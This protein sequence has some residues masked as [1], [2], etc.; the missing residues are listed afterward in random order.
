MRANL[1]GRIDYA[2]VRIF[3]VV[4]VPAVVCLNPDATRKPLQLFK[5]LSF[6]KLSG[7]LILVDT[8]KRRFEGGITRGTLYVRISCR[9]GTRRSMHASVSVD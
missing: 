3:N 5:V 1:C 7:L 2:Q 6:S 9:S 4:V 8:F